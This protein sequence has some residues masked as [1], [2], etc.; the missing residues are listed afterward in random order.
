MITGCYWTCQPFSECFPQAN[1]SMLALRMVTA[2]VLVILSG[3]FTSQTDVRLTLTW[4]SD[5]W[6]INSPQCWEPG[7][8][9]KHTM[10]VM[11]WYWTRATSVLD[12]CANHYTIHTTLPGQHSGLLKITSPKS[13]PYSGGAL[14]M[15][16]K[17]C[18]VHCELLRSPPSVSVLEGETN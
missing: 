3:S 16:W 13:Q 6:W 1:V 8:N 2:R 9:T 10:P 5:S 7:F 15:V 12:G 17:T 4:F 14:E 18:L 11:T